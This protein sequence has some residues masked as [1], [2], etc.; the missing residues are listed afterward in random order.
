MI[1]RYKVHQMTLLC[2][3]RKINTKKKTYSKHNWISVYDTFCSIHVS[4]KIDTKINKKTRES[5]TND[6]MLLLHNFFYISVQLISMYTMYVLW[7]YIM[8]KSEYIHLS[9]T[10]SVALWNSLSILHSFFL[11]HFFSLVFDSVFVYIYIYI[12]SFWKL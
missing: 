9:Q 1:S 5:I 6:Y 11:F 10:N 12:F 7:C 3:R 2:K 4:C 8:P